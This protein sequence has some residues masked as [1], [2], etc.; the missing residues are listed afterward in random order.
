MIT[1]YKF[2]AIGELADPSP[3]C[4]KV[5]AYLKLT[6]LEYE[7]KSGMKYMRGAP[8]GK[9]PYITDGDKAIADSQFIIGYLKQT[10]GD[11]VDGHLT[12]EQKAIGHAFIKMVDENLYWCV[13]HSRWINEGNWPKLKD[14]FFGKM[15][16]PLRAIISRVAQKRVK[17]ALYAHGLGRH[18]EAEIIEIGVRDITAL[19]NFLGDK[20]YFLGDQPSSLDASAYGVLAQ[21]TKFSGLSSPLYDAARGHQNLMDFINRFHERYFPEVK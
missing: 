10:Y 16:F 21:M 4:L 19:A 6:G 8:K 5:E 2:G 13:V 7:C 14:Y 15:P 17:K 20:P 11:K 3:F 9:L 1:L 12:D 18:S